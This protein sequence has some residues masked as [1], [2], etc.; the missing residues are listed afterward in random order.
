MATSG[1]SPVQF[2]IPPVRAKCATSD[3][4]REGVWRKVQTLPRPQRVA[5]SLREFYSAAT[6]SHELYP[7]ESAHPRS[8]IRQSSGNV[9]AIPQI[10]ASEAR[11]SQRTQEHKW[12]SRGKA[13]LVWP[14][15]A[16]RMWM[17]ID[18]MGARHALEKVHQHALRV[19]VDDCV[20]SLHGRQVRVEGLVEV[21]KCI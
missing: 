15:T 20:R 16:R 8:R 6:S 19:W 4:E 7:R 17:W 1:V 9:T 5:K 14:M 21:G 12:R 18:D 3:K 11:P 2:L 13:D 10:L